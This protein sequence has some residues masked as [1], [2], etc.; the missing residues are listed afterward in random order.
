MWFETPRLPLDGRDALSAYRKLG[1]LVSVFGR[2]A[3]R[4]FPSLLPERNF[5][6]LGFDGTREGLDRVADFVRSSMG[7]GAGEVPVRYIS[8]KLEARSAEE[9]VPRGD[10]EIAWYLRAEEGN[11][12]SGGRSR[13]LVIVDLD[14]LGIRAPGQFVAALAHEFAHHRIF[15]VRGLDREDEELADLLPILHGFGIFI[16]N[17]ALDCTASLSGLNFEST[18]RVQRT[19]Y[20]P[21]SVLAFTFALATVWKGEDPRPLRAELAP[22]P[23][24]VFVATLRYLVA[25][26]LRPWETGTGLLS[27]DAL[28]A[29]LDEEAREA[30]NLEDSSPPPEVKRVDT[31]WAG[32]FLTDRSE[33]TDSRGIRVFSE[34]LE[35]GETSDTVAYQ[36]GE[37]LGIAYRV[38]PD[39]PGE[40]LG[41]TETLEVFQSG[42]AAIRSDPGGDGPE[43]DMVLRYDRDVSGSDIAYFAVRMGKKPIQGPCGIVLQVFHGDLLLLRQEFRVLAADRGND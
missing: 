37:C 9:T 17:A 33:R 18:F 34:Y 27:P 28:E 38:I 19:G 35:Y 22:D 2:D 4:S 5:Q 23:R 26:G 42:V 21:Q 14:M 36:S 30:Q 29:A 7:L 10:G 43:P 1:R 13:S 24:H 15:S 12:D 20:L 41:I 3:L 31:I 16:A 8:A 11:R 6:P 40:T 25:R 39:Q 32:T